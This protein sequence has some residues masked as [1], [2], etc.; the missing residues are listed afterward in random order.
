[1]TET[2][3]K[4]DTVEEEK[5]DVNDVVQ[6]HLQRLYLEQQ[7]ER[8]ERIKKKSQARLKLLE[9]VRTMRKGQPEGKEGETVAKNDPAKV[10]AKMARS[11]QGW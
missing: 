9:E 11:G 2:A 3:V 5:E 10:S 6:N 1:M 7:R 8:H 4:V